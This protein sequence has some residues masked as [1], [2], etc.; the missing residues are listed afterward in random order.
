MRLTASHRRGEMNSILHGR[1]GFT[2]V[3]LLVVVAIIAILMAILLPALS[4]ARDK[5]R[6][7]R[8]MG[9]MNQAGTGLTMWHHNA[10]YYPGFD[11]ANSPLVT[12][13]N[14]GPWPDVLAMRPPFFTYENINNHRDFLE[15]RGRSPEDFTKTV[16][17]IE[18]FAC[19]ADKPHP[20]RINEARSRAWNLW[21]ADV[22]D[23]FEH[24]YGMGVGVCY[25]GHIE[26]PTGG[27]VTGYH[28][29][30]SGQ[31]LAADGVWCWIQNLCASYVDDPNSA[32]NQPFWHCN[33]MGYFHGN[34]RRAVV[35]CRDGSAKTIY[36][37]TEGR[38]IDTREVFVWGY[39]EGLDRFVR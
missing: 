7:A 19:P 34:F 31:L 35:V 32:F 10:E 25:E 33:C 23:G 14:L 39:G 18:I 15:K 28:K 26:S 3:E 20:H 1:Q 38:S 6:E 8:C 17:S 29:D 24:S 21:R 16:D 11:Y 2:L 4:L 9:N 37:G 27:F 30:A 5:A 12:S 13:P 36:Y 22:G